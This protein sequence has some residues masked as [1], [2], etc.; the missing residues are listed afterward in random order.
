VFAAPH[1]SGS[2]PAEEPATIYNRPAFLATADQFRSLGILCS[3]PDQTFRPAR[4]GFSHHRWRSR[5]SSAICGHRKGCCSHRTLVGVAAPMSCGGPMLSAAAAIRGRPALTQP[6]C[7][8]APHGCRQGRTGRHRGPE[9]ADLNDAARERRVGSGLDSAQAHVL[10][11]TVGAVDHG[12]GFAGQFVIQS[13]GDEAPD[14][15]R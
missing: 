5:T 2:G 7:L 6:K 12:V 4:N 1:E 3:G 15:R 9:P 14:D 11:T 13:G 8:A 10:S